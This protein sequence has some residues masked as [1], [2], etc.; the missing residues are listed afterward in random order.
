MSL[1]DTISAEDISDNQLG[2][3]YPSPTYSTP[4][5]IRYSEYD[6]DLLDDY[7][8]C[9]S[10]SPII[11]P[12]SLEQVDST[13]DNLE[14]RPMNTEMPS[15]IPSTIPEPLIS[16][17]LPVL[18]LTRSLS[19]PRG[20]YS[21]A[22][23]SGQD[24]CITTTPST[25]SSI[26]STPHSPLLPHPPPPSLL[27]GDGFMRCRGRPTQPLH[28]DNSPTTIY[29]LSQACA[30][31]S[32]MLEDHLQ[33]QAFPL[34]QKRMRSRDNLKLNLSPSS[35]RSS[36]LLVTPATKIRSLQ[37]SIEDGYRSS[38]LPELM[39]PPGMSA[40][41]NSTYQESSKELQHKMSLSPSSSSIT[42]VSE[43]K[44]GYFPSPHPQAATYWRN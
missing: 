30:G 29:Q 1:D 35:D 11:I 22:F 40:L 43:D 32:A 31:P 21:M 19:Q 33:D 28:L 12:D 44:D 15:T 7:R 10:V 39:T 3:F 23:Q 26:T 14:P 9:L 34:G 13:P 16:R 36:P 24:T 37:T 38:Q 2:Y 42:L 41:H 4:D 6:A 5:Y 27:T 25:T 18:I 17:S 8:K 20:T